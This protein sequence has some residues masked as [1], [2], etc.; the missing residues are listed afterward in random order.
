MAASN[1]S[2]VTD[3]MIAKVQTGSLQ[4]TE[5]KAIALAGELY[6]RARFDQAE[7]VC[8]QIIRHKPNIADAHNIL[9]VVLNAQGRADEGK[10]SIRKAIKLSP[11]T[12]SYYANLGEIE[13]LSGTL[14][15]AQQTLERAV[16]L[17]ANNAQA[18]NNLGIVYYEQKEFDRAIA[19]YQRALIALPTF[20]EAQNNLGNSLRMTGDLDGALMAYQA[21]LTAREVYPEAY[22]NLGTLL[23]EQK[24]V[25]QAQHA[26]KKAIQQNPN[27]VDAYNN[28]AALLHAE[29]NDVEALRQLSDVL[30]IAPRNPKSLLLTARIQLHRANYPAVE[31]AC[32]MVLHD[33]PANAEALTV[34][35]ELMH[36]LD[37]YDDAISLLESALK[38]D[39][40]SSEALNFYGVALKSVGRLDE[41]RAQIMKALDRND[42]MY[43]AYANLNDLVNYSQ[44]PELFQQIEAIMEA[45]DDPDTER[46]L[47]LHYAYAK[48]L[49]DVGQHAKALDHF[50]IG[51]RLKAQ[52]LNYIEENTFAFFNDIKA[53]FPPEIFRNRPFQGLDTDRPVFIVGMP[54]SGSTLVEQIISAHSGVFGAGEVKYLSRSLHNL[55]DRFPTLSAY[56]TVISEMNDKQFEIVAGEYLKSISASAGNAKKITDKLLTN[57]FFVGMIHLLFPQAKIVNTIRNPVDTCLSAFSKL[58]KDDMPHSYD[59]GEIGRYYRQYEALM[60][61]WNEVL[62]AGVLKTVR[63]EDTVKATEQTAREVIDFIGLPWEDSCLEFHNSSRPVKTASVAQVRKPIYKSAVE[64][65]RKYGDGLQPLLDAL[66]DSVQNY[67]AAKGAGG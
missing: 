17:D 5:D 3:E 53:Q 10:T 33:D 62:P 25:D 21:A 54:R 19:A 2:S 66:G 15:E 28:L 31:Q 34:L 67:H 6:N 59:L 47:P 42:S 38:L 40:E 50:I 48:A 63:Y 43:G 58:F 52:Q 49:D 13:R 29:R 56:P 64:R 61:H 30:R 4:M 18:H 20:P 16:S 14:E 23:R 65:W 60:Q 7:R 32:R 24:K 36:D 27:Y 26:M 22:N 9:G 57:Y 8:R 55:R 46:M 41:A 37:R 12:A 39:P 11:K 1:N 44:E 35:G 45:S 51:G